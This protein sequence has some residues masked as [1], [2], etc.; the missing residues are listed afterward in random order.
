MTYSAIRLLLSEA[1]TSHLLLTLLYVVVFVASAILLSVCYRFSPLHPLASYPGPRSWWFTNLQLVRLAMSGKRHQR[2][3]RLHMQYG[4][5]VRV[6]KR[7]SKCYC[8]ILVSRLIIGHNTLS[9]N[10]LSALNP[11]YG[12]ALSM[13]KSEM[14]RLPGHQDAMCLFYKQDLH[15]HNERK[16]VWMKSLS[17]AA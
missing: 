8:L 13:E 16:R 10:S 5:I 11:L 14:Y 15:L 2:L 6:G 4:P 3:H 17:A 1:Q 12:P 9:I 7:P